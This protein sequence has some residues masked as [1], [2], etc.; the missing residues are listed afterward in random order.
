MPMNKK[1]EGI[2]SMVAALL[3]L[4][5]A[6]WDPLVSLIIAFVALFASGVYDLWQGKKEKRAVNR[7]Q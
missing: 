7:T 4:F 1:K 6:V 5:S 3:V 2:I